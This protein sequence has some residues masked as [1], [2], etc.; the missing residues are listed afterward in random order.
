MLD[1]LLF[2]FQWWL[3]VL[4]NYPYFYYGYILAIS[5]AVLSLF[6]KYHSPF[7]KKILFATGLA[8]IG[9]GNDILLAYLK[10][11][12]LPGLWLAALWFCFAAWF[13]EAEWI[14]QKRLL[15]TVSFMI[16]GPLSYIAG[17]K[18]NA[19]VFL[20]FSYKTL[21]LLALD[22]LMLGLVFTQAYRH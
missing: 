17:A 20:A 15:C 16:L 12:E 4:H 8:S 9:M 10:I 11:F 14:N 1:F 13:V 5:S 22:W 3:C 21:F 7:H 19:L 18:L 6:L 2:Q